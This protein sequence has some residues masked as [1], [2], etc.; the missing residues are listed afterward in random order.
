M[1]LIGRCQRKSD[2]APFNR[3]VD[4]LMREPSYRHAQEVNGTGRWTY[5]AS[6]HRGDDV[7]V[8]LSPAAGEG[9][10]FVGATGSFTVAETD[11]TWRDFRGKGTLRYVGERYLRFDNDE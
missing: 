5:T 3:L 2:I 7:A 9:T 8:S 6:F 1:E 11:K 10:A 4:A